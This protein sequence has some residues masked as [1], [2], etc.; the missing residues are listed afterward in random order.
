M[1]ICL[2]GF[3]S[4]FKRNCLNFVRSYIKVNESRYRQCGVTPHFYSVEKAIEKK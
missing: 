2:G 1:V 4:N 3:R